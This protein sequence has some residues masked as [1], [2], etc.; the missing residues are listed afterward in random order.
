M[1][2]FPGVTFQALRALSCFYEL[3]YTFLSA[4]Y[5][6]CLFFFPYALLNHSSYDRS[7]IVIRIDKKKAANFFTPFEVKL[8][9]SWKI[10]L[11]TEKRSRKDY[12]RL[13]CSK[14]VLGAWPKDFWHTIFC[15]LRLL[16]HFRNFK[17]QEIR[18]Y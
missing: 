18:I 17:R 4:V 3:F 10:G 7:V 12:K 1:Q 15:S 16:A 8:K 5:C 13:V 6:F 14:A 2:L 11:R 9:N